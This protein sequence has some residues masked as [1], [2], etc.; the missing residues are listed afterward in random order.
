MTQISFFQKLSKDR[1]RI[2]HDGKSGEEITTLDHYEQ[3]RERLKNNIWV[4]MVDHG[5]EIEF[6]SPTMEH[7]FRVVKA[8]PN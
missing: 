1:V 4:E 5:T 6:R 2:T 7:S 8:N 3:I